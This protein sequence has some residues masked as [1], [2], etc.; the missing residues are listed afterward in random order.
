MNHPRLASIAL[1]SCA[2]ASAADAQ[3]KRPMTFADIMDIKGIGG[4]ALAPDA[5]VVA[6]AVTG[7]E[8]PNAKPSTDPAKPDTSRGDRHET[9]SHLWLVPTTGGTPRQLTYSERGESQPQWSPDGKTL[10]FLS[11]RGTGEDV[12]TQV[13]LLPMGGGEAHQLTESRESITGFAWSK[14]GSRIAFLAVDTMPKVDEAKRRRRDDPLVYEGNQRLSHVWVI[15]V[16]TKKADEIVH[17][18]FTVKGAP[19]W[20]PD[21]RQLAYQASPSTLLRETRTDAYV[22]TIADKRNERIS[23]TSD[24]ASTPAFSPDGRTIAFTILPQE[25]KPRA[26]SISD[27]EIGNNHLLLYDVAARTTKDTYDPKLDVSAGTPQWTPDGSRILYWT[28]ERAYNAVYAYD[29]ATGKLS[30][31]VDKLLGR[32]LSFSRDGKTVAFA[33]DRGDTPADVY[34]SDLTFASPRKLTDVNPQIRGLAIGET[35]VVTWKSKDGTPS[36]AFSSSP[37]AI[38]RDN[39]IRC[40]SKHTVDQREHPTPASK[41]TGDR[42]DRCGP[43]KDG[44]SSIRTRAARPATV[45]SSRA[46]TSWIG[47]AATTATS[48]QASTRWSGAGSPIRRSSPSR[49]GATADT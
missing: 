18:S 29:V 44:P 32:G 31:V 43:D 3:A 13:W 42:P 23:G 5:S 49:A 17:G 24:V 35:E 6:Y 48:C 47:A 4:V 34:V 12:K 14:D 37:S 40:S 19:T 22:V 26:D 30:R 10:A 15:D 2:L 8:H 41:R 33:M 25:H 46:R 7:W 28:G 36:R 21:G 11:S 20:S 27:V 45:K 1:L 9:R 16:A 38:R 39:G